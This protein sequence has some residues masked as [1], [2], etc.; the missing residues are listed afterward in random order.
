MASRR[1]GGG[2]ETNNMSDFEFYIPLDIYTT[3]SREPSFRLFRYRGLLCLIRRTMM[4]GHLCGYVSVDKDHPLRGKDYHD[5]IV[6][7]DL[8]GIKFNHNYIGLFCTNGDELDA[9]IVPMDLFINVHCGLTFA[10]DYAPEIDEDL[11]PGLWWFGFDTAHSGDVAPFQMRMPG[12]PTSRWKEDTYKDYHY[13]YNE[14]CK[15]ADQLLLFVPQKPLIDIQPFID[16]LDALRA[17]LC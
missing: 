5:K 12:L 11:F 8:R 16:R 9:G 2:G 4:L 6:A 7:D 1:G 14:T 3:M 10:R 15:L 17:R 13:V